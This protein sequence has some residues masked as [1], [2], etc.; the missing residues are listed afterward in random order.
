MLL[1]NDIV[2]VVYSL[3]IKLEPKKFAVFVERIKLVSVFL[4]MDVSIHVVE[5][6]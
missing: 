1:C 3:V 6:I 5:L 2:R 4:W